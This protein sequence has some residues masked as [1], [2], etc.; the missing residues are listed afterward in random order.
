MKKINFICHTN[1][2]GLWSYEERTV[3]INDLKIGYLTENFGELR[4]YFGNKNW[5]TEKHGLI[6]TDRLFIKELRKNLEK[7]G[8]S[9]KAA[10]DVDYSEQG[11]QGDNYVSLDFGKYFFKELFPKTFI[12][13]EDN[14]F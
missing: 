1:G 6:Y 13:F 9:K 8:F 14:V 11:M 2:S 3:K 5:D 12:T 7:I 10:N 4:A